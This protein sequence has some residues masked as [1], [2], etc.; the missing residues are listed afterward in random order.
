[1]IAEDF[2]LKTLWQLCRLR[3]L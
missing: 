3:L 2:G 1:V